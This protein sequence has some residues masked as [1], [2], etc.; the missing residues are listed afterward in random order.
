MIVF[1]LTFRA[2]MSYGDMLQS[3]PPGVMPFL[4]PARI[5]VG[6]SR[7]SRRHLIA[8]TILLNGITYFAPLSSAVVIVELDLN[9]STITDVSAELACNVSKTPIITK[10][11]D[12][13][14]QQLQ[15]GRKN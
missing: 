8:A 5:A 11:L 2:L 14:G 3:K 10:I 12:S 9:V 6:L 15:R 1:P 4:S 7:S 13:S